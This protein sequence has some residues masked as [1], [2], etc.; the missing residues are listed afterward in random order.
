MKVKVL[1]YKTWQGNHVKVKNYHYRKNKIVLNP[2]YEFH[3]S[4]I[5]HIDSV[6][7]LWKKE[8]GE[9]LKERT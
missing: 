1:E 6:F 3:K 2:K 8:Y 9:E 7:L 5:S 4:I